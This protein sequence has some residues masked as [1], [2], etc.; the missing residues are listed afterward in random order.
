[1][2]VKYYPESNYEINELTLS[3]YINSISD[4]YMNIF[5][6]NNKIEDDTVYKLCK[7]ELEDLLR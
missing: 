2:R 5:L 6:N 3:K 1:V 4:E 7:H